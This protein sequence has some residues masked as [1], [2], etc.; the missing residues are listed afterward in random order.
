MRRIVTASRPS[1]SMMRSAAA[2]TRSRVR[3]SR[4]GDAACRARVGTSL[5]AA[6]SARGS[7]LTGFRSR[8]MLPYAVSIHR[9]SRVGQSRRRRGERGMRINP[10]SLARASSRHP[11]RTVAVWLLI[12]VAGIASAA[13]LLG[14]AL[15]TEFDFT[16]VPEAKRAQLLLEERQLEEDIV[17]ETFVVTTDSGDGI[18]DPAFAEQVNGLLGDL[19]A[20]GPE[21][22]TTVPA[23]YPL[24]EAAAADPLVAALGPI[25]SEDG[26]AVLFTAVLAGDVDEATEHALDVAEVRDA[27]SAD[28]VEVYQLGQVSSSEDFKK[29]S[30]E[31]LRFGESI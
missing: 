28:G 26:T 13:T 20:L 7:G 1:A 2:A 25:P 19:S 6:I 24:S 11:G 21:V 8:P 18:Q 22:V 30:E 17:T 15:T 23:A 14:P 4:A 9:T 16:N 10:E 12:L 31:D 5:A 27:W 3:R 29:I